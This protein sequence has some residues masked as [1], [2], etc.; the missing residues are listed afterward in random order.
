MSKVAKRRTAAPVT[1]AAERMVTQQLVASAC[2]TPADAVRRLG[3]VQAQDYLGS[4]WGIAQRCAP[5]ADEA[6]VE[7][8]VAAREIV[9]GWPMRG[10]LHFTAGADLKWMTAMLAARIV[11]RTA[12]Y[13]ELGLDDAAFATCRRAAERELA[14]G[15][16]RARDEMYALFERAGVACAGQ[17]GFHLLG[18]LAMT[19]TLCFGPRRGKQFTFTLLDA[20]IPA[21]RALAGDEALAELAIRYVAGHAPAGL[22]DFAWWTGLNL[23]ECRR[24]FAAAGAALVERDGLYRPASGDDRPAAAGPRVYLLPPWDELTV[25]YRD[26]SALLD[27]AHATRL[28]N[29]IFSPVVV[30]DGRVAGTWRRTRKRDHVAITCDLLEPPSRPIARELDAAAARYGT[31]LGTTAT[32]TLA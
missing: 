11:R 7:A 21:S 22:D 3:A 13:R 23:G 12:R 16:L 8:A 18:Y 19:G 17:R 25:G 6:H 2:A 1:V 15:G 28:G 29:G 20:W 10:T 32:L 31:F 26:R 4:L 30:V 24:A 14:G 9:R 5:A 27:A